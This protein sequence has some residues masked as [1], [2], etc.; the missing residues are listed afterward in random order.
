MFIHENG[1]HF[2]AFTECPARQAGIVDETGDIIS[3]A[4]NATLTGAGP[5][6]DNSNSAVHKLQGAMDSGD[7]NLSE[8]LN[9]A[10]D[11]LVKIGHSKVSSLDLK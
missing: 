10:L 7:T 8:P 11:D 9:I 5:V 2:I 1:L 6:V 4:G 3:I